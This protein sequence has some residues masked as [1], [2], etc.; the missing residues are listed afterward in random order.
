M[1]IALCLSGLMHGF[2]ES[3]PFLEKNLI[4]T[5]RPDIFMHTWD[6]AGERSL[7]T[8]AQLKINEETK[9]Q[10]IE[11]YQPKEVVFESFFV[12][13]N[14]T[15]KDRTAGNIANT[16]AMFYKIKKC[17]ELKSE[18]E[19]KHG[20]IYD[21]VIRCRFD[22]RLETSLSIKDLIKLS[23]WLYIPEGGDWGGINDQFAFSSSKNMDIY[24]S[25]SNYLDEYWHRGCLFHPE[26]LLQYHLEECCLPY[27]RMYLHYRLA[28]SSRNFVRD[29]YVKK[30]SAW[31]QKKIWL[32]CLDQIKSPI[33][34][35]NNKLF[36]AFLILC[37]LK[38]QVAT[39]EQFIF[40]MSPPKF[41]NSRFMFL[42]RLT[43]IWFIVIGRETNSHYKHIF[44]K[45][46]EIDYKIK[47]IRKYFKKMDIPL[48]L[49]NHVNRSE[50]LF[51]LGPLFL[52]I[53][54][55]L[56]H[57]SYRLLK[58]VLRKLFSPVSAIFL[59]SKQN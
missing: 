51:Q 4:D 22:M 7:K 28:G 48:T 20:F 45:S 47:N 49:V 55:K 12:F 58:R 17:N 30:K 43:N 53:F 18:Y 14:Q 16:L 3:F 52:F 21:A 34:K 15:Y 36:L 10:V 29:A 24:S 40:L 50:L 25:I 44:C 37:S 26:T 38:A 1:R 35:V 13:D 9:K 2:E 19:K 5:L 46:E 56:I 39:K 31:R 57:K 23:E 8:V 59:N 11:M 42:N 33:I 41:R 27:K 32:I 54:T 6:I